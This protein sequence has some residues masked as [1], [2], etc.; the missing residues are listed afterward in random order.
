MTDKNIEALFAKWI[1]K[2]KK[3]LSRKIINR[4]ETKAKRTYIHFDKRR[5]SSSF[6]FFYNL[7]NI[8]LNE[9][10]VA[11]N[12]FWP[13]LKITITT[14][15]IKNKKNKLKRKKERKNRNVYYASHRDALIY[16]W[17]SFLLN[18]KYYKDKINELG[19]N[20]CVIA[21]RKIPIKNGLNKNKCNIHLAKEVFD[22][23]KNNNKECVAFVSDITGFFDNLDHEHLKKEWLR[24]LNLDRNTDLPKDHNVI[25]KNL[26][27]FKYVEAKK[28]YKKFRIKFKRK[29][30]KQNGKIKIF[31]IP[32]VNGT[33]IENIL[34]NRYYSRKDFVTRVVKGGLIKGNGNR[35][36][37]KQCT[38]GIMQGSP[39]SATL[40][41]IYMMSF[42]K[43]INDLVTDLGGI[44]RRYSDDLVIVCDISKHDIV[45]N[46]VQEE[47]KKYELEI[48]LNKTDTTYFLKDCEGRLKGFNNNNRLSRKNMQYLGFDFS[49]S[50]IYIRCSSL[51]KYYRAMKSKVR[52]TVNMACGKRSR[53]ETKG[54]KNKI[55]KKSLYKKYLYKGRRSFISYALRANKIIGTETIKKQLRKRFDIMR[56][57]IN[58]REKKKIRQKK[59]KRFG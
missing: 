24:I 38:C 12:P 43:T 21:Y 37:R 48:N 52:K 19:I 47:I 32:E 22:Y 56:D 7:K 39:I 58:K 54:N 40:S 45:K 1:E 26:T 16:S 27:T 41:N 14:P 6:S 17:Y 51:T 35:N 5:Q 11:Q 25:Y 36:K 20:R 4:E 9:D 3:N 59:K 10:K 31:K 49:G 42:D 18:E 23:I 55:F 28:I 8:L 15:R 2:E 50:K 53:T 29:K 34:D 30:K 44:Y 33:P 57:Y 13:F 46:K